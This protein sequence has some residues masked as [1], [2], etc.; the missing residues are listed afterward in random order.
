MPIIKADRIGLDLLK[1]FVIEF[2]ILAIVIIALF[3]F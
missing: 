2:I 1:I 3:S